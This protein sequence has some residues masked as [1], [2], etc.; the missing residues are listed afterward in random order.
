[1]AL[2]PRN[3]VTNPARTGADRKLRNRLVLASLLGGVALYGGLFLVGAMPKALEVPA[4]VGLAG[5]WAVANFFI[6]WRRADWENRATRSKD[7][8]LHRERRRKALGGD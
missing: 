7:E 1:M 5:I 6:S 3:L 2:F 8:A 4:V